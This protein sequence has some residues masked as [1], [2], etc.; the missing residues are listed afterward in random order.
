MSNTGIISADNLKKIN[1]AFPEDKYPDMTKAL[2]QYQKG[3][4][5]TQELFDELEKCYDQDKTEYIK[6][7]TKKSLMDTE[8]LDTMKTNYPLLFSELQ[9]LYGEDLS[10]WKSLEQAKLDI[11][12]ETVSQ[13][14]KL[15]QE[16][17][18]AMGVDNY[19]EF[20]GQVVKKAIANGNTNAFAASTLSKMYSQDKFEKVISDSNVKMNGKDVNS[21]Y[22]KLQDNISN[23]L[24]S[25]EKMKG[26]LDNYDNDV[27]DALSGRLSNLDWSTLGDDS[28]SSSSS[29]TAEKLNWIERLINKISTAYSR[30]KNIV[31]D[32]T[33]TWLN[34][35]NAL[36]DS[37]S[38]R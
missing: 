25:A 35:N 28:S 7:L 15:Y 18:K 13:I 21:E 26:A 11:S 3:L 2:V 14:A 36:A 17:Y 10:G 6:A 34:R 38:V 37:M 5:T 22:Q 1:E 19:V 32:T 20:N 4:I 30:L 33:T 24:S 8:F 9:G 31:S 27:F 12:A 29:Q 16:F 23:V